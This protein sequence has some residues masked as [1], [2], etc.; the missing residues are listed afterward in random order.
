M[1]ILQMIAIVGALSLTACTGALDLGIPEPASPL[2]MISGLES[3]F[4]Q[5][6]GIN[7]VATS[8]CGALADEDLENIFT[9]DEQGKFIVHRLDANHFHFQ[10]TDIMANNP[11]EG[12]ADVGWLLYDM[13]NREYLSPDPKRPIIY[14][15]E[16]EYYIPDDRAIQVTLLYTTDTSR[17][18]PNNK[19]GVYL[20]SSMVM[21]LRGGGEGEDPNPRPCNAQPSIWIESWSVALGGHGYGDDYL[22]VTFTTGGERPNGEFRTV[23]WNT[24]TAN[25]AR[26]TIPIRTGMRTIWILTLQEKSIRHFRR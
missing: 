24:V 2:A 22:V 7:P 17:K 26:Q 23:Q 25:L 16:M 15:C 12:F 18:N 5:P 3:V 11:Q 1:K 6:Q 14:G 20:T 10:V 19:T 9:S 4:I 13:D 21:D 8:P